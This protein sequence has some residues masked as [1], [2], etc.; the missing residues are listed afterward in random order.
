MSEFSRLSQVL[1][2]HPLLEPPEL[3]VLRARSRRRQRRRLAGFSMTAAVVVLGAFGLITL[4]AGGGQGKARLAAYFE[5]GVSVPDGTLAAVGLPALVTAPTKV[6]PVGSTAASE[7]AVVYVGAGYCPYCAL[8]RWALLVA[9]SKF[10]TFSELS[11]AVYSSSSDI[12]PDLASW[13]FV[14]AQYT[15]PYFSFE[16]AELDSSTPDTQGAYQPLQTMTPGE[17]AAYEQFDP[18]RGLP[19]VDIGNQ[20]VTVGASASPAP[21]EGLSLEQIGSSLENASS[22]VAQAVDGSANYLV[23]AMCKVVHGGGPAICSTATTSEALAAM[24]SGNPP[25]TTTTSTAPG[26][27]TTLPQS[28]GPSGSSSGAAGESSAIQQ[29]ALTEVSNGMSPPKLEPAPFEQRLLAVHPLTYAIYREALSAMAACAE[30]AMPGLKVTFSPNQGYPYL[31]DVEA[32]APQG[33]TTPGSAGGSSTVNPMN[34]TMAMCESQY[35]AQVEATWTL[36][37]HDAGQ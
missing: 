6:T 22:P 32:S 7:G 3:S 12:Y 35:S 31:E 14:G 34:A 17:Q 33:S 25:S 13:S 10:G 1:I 16:P 2:D 4:P 37:D 19:F 9:L 28:T 11:N 20:Y 27:P 15:S 5:E 23:A 26:A 8:Q 18:Q 36:Q 24:G 30:Q 29:L 21:L